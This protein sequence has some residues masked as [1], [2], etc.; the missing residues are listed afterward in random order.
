MEGMG[1]NGG[2]GMMN[3]PPMGMGGMS[4]GSILGGMGPYGGMGGMGGPPMGMEAPPMGMGG[5]TMGM[6]GIGASPN[7]FGAYGGMGMGGMGA[8]LVN[9]GA[10]MGRGNATMVSPMPSDGACGN[11]ASTVPVNDEDGVGQGE[12]KEEAGVGHPSR[13]VPL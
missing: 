12:E 6:G 13:P 4:F 2:M 10:T 7:I 5:P 1:G 8:P 3:A 9:L 11:S